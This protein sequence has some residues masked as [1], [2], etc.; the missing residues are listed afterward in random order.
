MAL[1]PEPGRDH[2]PPP[3]LSSP[4]ADRVLNLYSACMDR[5]VA[6]LSREHEGPRASF[7]PGT[8]ASRIS[9]VWPLTREVSSLSR[10][11]DAERR[12]QRDVAVLSR[13]RR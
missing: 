7:V 4:A 12:L 11:H 13:R 10:R 2:R 5:T 8:P 9:M 6:T 1:R 3:V